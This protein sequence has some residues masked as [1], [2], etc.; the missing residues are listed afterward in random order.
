[1][2]WLKK[3]FGILVTILGWVF[4]LGICYSNINQLEKEITSIKNRQTTFEMTV[5]D[6]N[7]TITSID[8]KMNLLLDNKL[9]VKGEL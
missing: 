3:N 6:M 2:E 4:S 9:V 8:T 7:K 5:N 1:M